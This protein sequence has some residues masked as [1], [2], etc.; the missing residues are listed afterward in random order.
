MLF[1]VGA[2]GVYDDNISYFHL[3]GNKS[4]PYIKYITLLNGMCIRLAMD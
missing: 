2:I 4:R 3:L 1:T